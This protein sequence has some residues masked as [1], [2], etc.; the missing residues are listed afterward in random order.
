MFLRVTQIYAAFDDGAKLPT[1]FFL[2]WDAWKQQQLGNYNL[3]NAWNAFESNK[4]MQYVKSCHGSA[5]LNTNI[6]TSTLAEIRTFL[7]DRYDSC[8]SENMPAA[9]RRRRKWP[10]NLQYYKSD[11]R[12]R[13]QTVHVCTGDFTDDESMVPGKQQEASDVADWDLSRVILNAKPGVRNLVAL[14]C[15][16]EFDQS[17]KWVIFWTGS[18]R[19]ITCG[20]GKESCE[21]T[22]RQSIKS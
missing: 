11:I 7:L 12:Q 19:P 3:R 15:H 5:Y 10:I 16:G 22:A 18:P 1:C 9:L 8:S 2:F 21:M 4:C 20:D 14:M 6:T 13:R 17:V